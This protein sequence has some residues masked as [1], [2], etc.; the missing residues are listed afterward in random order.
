MRTVRG[1]ACTVLTSSVPGR[2]VPTQLSALDY[3]TVVVRS[4]TGT[5]R[6]YTR[7]CSLAI[8]NYEAPRMLEISPF[9]VTG[10]CMGLGSTEIQGCS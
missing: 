2:A 10:Y 5:V 8:I 9:Q 7:Y 1:V 3:R 6:V 4:T